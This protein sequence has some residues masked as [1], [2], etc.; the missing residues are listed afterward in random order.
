M[1]ERDGRAVARRNELQLLKALHKHGW[2]RSRDVAALLWHRIRSTPM[3][4][5]FALDSVT[6]S[7]SAIRMAQRTLSRLRARHQIICHGAPDGAQ[8]YGLSEAGARVLR[9]LDIPARSGKDWLR[10]FSIQQYHHRRLSTEIAI[11]AMLQGYRVA[12][13][14]EIAMGTWIGGNGGV[15]GKKPDVL[16][17]SGKLVWWLEVERSRRNRHDYI[18][19]LAWLTQLW[20]ASS[21]ISPAVLPGEHLLQQVVFISNMAF[22][23]RLKLDLGKLGWNDEQIKM[24]IFGIQL[25]YVTEASFLY[26]KKEVGADLVE[27]A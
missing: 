15:H 21:L 16:V 24:R 23:E 2:L 7:H 25:L 4:G 12:T 9:E 22:F 1:N 10:R 17:R 19:L 11:T 8:I 13:E 6:V 27:S 26:I 18:K 14:H 5:S 3:K 20:P